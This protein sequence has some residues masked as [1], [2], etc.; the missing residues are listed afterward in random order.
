MEGSE[1]PEEKLISRNYRA[2]GGGGE[3]EVDSASH[4]GS[5]LW[6]EGCVCSEGRAAR[7]D[8]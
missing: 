5:L 4:P 2:D 6:L 1:H 7:P 3:E 8:F